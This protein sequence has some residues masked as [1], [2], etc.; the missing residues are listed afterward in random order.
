M[1]DGRADKRR[2]ADGARVRVLLLRT[3]LREGR[4]RPPEA[5]AMPVRRGEARAVAGAPEEA[6]RQ[7]VK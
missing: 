4:E 2:P 1:C 3:V 7:P 5:G 6:R